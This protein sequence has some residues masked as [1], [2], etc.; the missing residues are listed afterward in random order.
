MY[1]IV[2]IQ[3]CNIVYC[4]PTLPDKVLFGD[5]SYVPRLCSYSVLVYNLQLFAKIIFCLF[6]S[7]YLLFYIC[8]T[9]LMTSSLMSMMTSSVTTLMTSSCMTSSVMC[10]ITQHQKQTF[11]IHILRARP[12]RSRLLS[13]LGGLANSLVGGMPPGE[14]R[15]GFLDT[16]QMLFSS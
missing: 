9:W 13:T 1:C 4:I 5:R 16:P 8:V 3:Y 2:P 11:H 14:V 6:F 7:G 15:S 12:P 10:P